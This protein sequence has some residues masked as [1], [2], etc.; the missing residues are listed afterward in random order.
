M[1][2]N[3]KRAVENIIRIGTCR[4]PCCFDRRFFSFSIKEKISRASER[5]N[6]GDNGMAEKRVGWV[7]GFLSRKKENWGFLSFKTLGHKSLASSSLS[8]FTLLPGLGVVVVAGNGSSSSS[9]SS[10]SSSY[11]TRRCRT[12]F[13]FPRFG[14]LVIV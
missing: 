7:G 1:S 10:S 9:L 8:S 14:F 2:K 6:G 5:A 4:R 13:L 3:K 11:S 12:W